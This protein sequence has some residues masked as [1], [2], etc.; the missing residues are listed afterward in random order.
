VAKQRP[1]GSPELS[2]AAE[3]GIARAEALDAL[4]RPIREAGEADLQKTKS[5]RKLLEATRSFGAD[6]SAV[7]EGIRSGKTSQDEGLRLAHERQQEFR[8]RYGARLAEANAR[9]AHLQPSVEAVAMILSPETAYRTT[10]VAETSFLR[11]MLL[12]PRQAR[13]E[14]GTVRQ[15]L[16]DPAPP[17]AVQSCVTPPYG[18]REDYQDGFNVLSVDWGNE[19]TAD[20]LTGRAVIA[21]NCWCSPPFNVQ[22]SIKSAFVGQDFPVPAG[23][24][25]YTTTITYDWICTGGGAAFLGVSIVNVDLAIVIDKRDGTRDIQAREISLLTVPFAGGD[26]FT[27]FATGVKVTIPFTRDG[28]NGTVRIMVGAD[29]NCTTVAAAGGAYFRADATVREICISSAG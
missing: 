8:E 20:N 19:A 29:G 23:P 21:G 4:Y 2:E 12:R 11:S 17:I 1:K 9:H 16:G 28:S 14:A 24:T 13:E 6:L 22:S 5:G 27:H 25:K 18:R 10:W 26:G 15:G 7:Y 3:R